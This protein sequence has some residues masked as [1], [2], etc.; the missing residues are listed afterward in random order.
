MEMVK[1][2]LLHAA[3]QGAAAVCAGVAGKDG[4]LP[5]DPTIQDAGLRD[6]GLLVYELAKV[7]YHA[8]LRA[9]HDQSGVWPDP[10]VA[11]TF[12]VPALLDQALKLLPQLMPIVG[13][14]I[15]K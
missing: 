14:L 4:P 10:R 3:Y 13:G 12:D 15:R 1:A 8:L 5:L 6:K 11:S 9:F 7:Q 2:I